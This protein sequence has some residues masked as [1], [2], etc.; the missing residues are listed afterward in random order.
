KRTQL[1]LDEALY[2]A[3]RRRAYE[4]RTSVAAVVRETLAERFDPPQGAPARAAKGTRGAY[5]PGFSWIGIG[6]SGQDQ[7]RPLSRYHDEAFAQDYQ[8]RH[9]GV[10][11]K[12]TS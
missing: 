4:R 1:Q 3:V 8:A 9:P 12:R 2:D 5:P 11:R 6:R 10:D 7:R